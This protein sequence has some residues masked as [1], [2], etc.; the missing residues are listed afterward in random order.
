LSKA[1]R[2]IFQNFHAV[3]SAAKI[4]EK[5]VVSFVD[6]L[7]LGIRLATSSSNPLS[8][9]S[10]LFQEKWAASHRRQPELSRQT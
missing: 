1:F 6:P 7:Q 10:P 2:L 8:E 5:N 9:T 4:S 3:L